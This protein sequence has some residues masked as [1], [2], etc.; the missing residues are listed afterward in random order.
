LHTNKTEIFGATVDNGTI[1]NR[2]QRGRIS[3][4]Q[5]IGQSSTGGVVGR[6]NGEVIHIH[7]IVL[8]ILIKIKLGGPSGCQGQD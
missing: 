4:K 5:G 6:E 3:L 2:F 7:P 1:S 8:E